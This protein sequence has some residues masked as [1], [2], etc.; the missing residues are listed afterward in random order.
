ME[1]TDGGEVYSPNVGGTSFNCS[2]LPRAEKEQDNYAE[3]IIIFKR[4]APERANLRFAPSG[5]P[6]SRGDGLGWTESASMRLA[7][8]AARSES[9]YRAFADVR[10]VPGFTRSGV[11]LKSVFCW[12]SSLLMAG[13]KIELSGL[14]ERSILAVFLPKTNF[15]KHFVPIF[16]PISYHPH[17]RTGRPRNTS[18]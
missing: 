3:G 15:F 17:A 4:V 8:G 14:G 9:L 2:F 12:Q 7:S 16:T 13:G 5:L 6:H 1:A 10:P 11:Q 18:L